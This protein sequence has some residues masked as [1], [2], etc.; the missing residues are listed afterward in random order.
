MGSAAPPSMRKRRA[1][2]PLAASPST[3]S[4]TFSAETGIPTAPRHRRRDVFDHLVAFLVPAG[5]FAASR[6][7]SVSLR[8][9]SGRLMSSPCAAIQAS[10]VAICCSCIRTIIG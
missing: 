3:T 1:P 8:M 4:Y 10:S 7:N 5:F 6:P 9:A 2:K